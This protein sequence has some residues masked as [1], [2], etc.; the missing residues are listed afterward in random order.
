MVIGVERL[1]GL[2]LRKNVSG[3]RSRV[4]I[5]LLGRRVIRS[6]DRQVCPGLLGKGRGNSMRTIGI[7]CSI[8]LI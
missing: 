8:Y 2:I 5:R 3:T 4:A 1:E 6:L 7:S